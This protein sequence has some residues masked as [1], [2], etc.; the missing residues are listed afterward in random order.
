MLEWNQEHVQRLLPNWAP[1]PF[2][3]ERTFR[4]QYRCYD[5]AGYDDSS[6]ANLEPQMEEEVEEEGEGKEEMDEEGLGLSHD[7]KTS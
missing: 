7:I 4:F 2:R 3:I 6:D 1:R 5:K